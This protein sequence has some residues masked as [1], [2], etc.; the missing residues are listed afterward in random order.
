M[1]FNVPHEAHAIQTHLEWKSHTQHTKKGKAVNVS[2]AL[3]ENEK[4]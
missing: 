4:Y 1:P 3:D 2:M